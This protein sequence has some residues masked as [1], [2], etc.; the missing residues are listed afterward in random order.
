MPYLP[1]DYDARRETARKPLPAGAAGR[2]PRLPGS[3]GRLIE[4]SVNSGYLHF[5]ARSNR[6]YRIFSEVTGPEYAGRVLPY[7]VE[8]GLLHARVD[9]PHLLERCHYMKKEWIRDLNLEMGEDL[10]TDMIFRV[11]PPG[12]PDPEPRPPEPVKGLPDDEEW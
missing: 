8:L 2:P 11:L 5:L 7:G 4:E 9:S 6:L 12:A 3:V 10:V 1:E